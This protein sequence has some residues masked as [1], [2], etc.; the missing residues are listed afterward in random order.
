MSGS[1]LAWDVVDYPEPHLERTRALLSAHPEV[2]TLFGR[3][4]STAFWVVLIVALQIAGAWAPNF[5]PGIH[6]WNHDD[7]HILPDLD[8][9]TKRG[10]DP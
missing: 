3:E 9:A 8:A 4:R 6:P 2:R 10:A 5:L 7:P 1:A